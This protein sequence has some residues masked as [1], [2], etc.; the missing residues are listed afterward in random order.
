MIDR[1]SAVVKRAPGRLALAAVGL[2]AAPAFAAADGTSPVSGD[3]QTIVVTGERG[4]QSDYRASSSTTATRTDTPLINVPQSITVVTARNLQDRA[5]NSIAD[6]VAYV[7]GVQSSQG[8][9]NR[10]TLVLRGNTVTG[11]FF[12]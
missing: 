12:V 4:A 10:D 11:D 5:A 9:N 2:F 3:D 7:P 8:E 6:A 1:V